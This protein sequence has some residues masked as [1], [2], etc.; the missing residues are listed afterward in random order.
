MISPHQ[1]FSSNILLKRNKTMEKKRKC[2]HWLESD[3]NSNNRIQKKDQDDDHT[4]VSMDEF[5]FKM[6][7]ALV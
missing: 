5:I 7:G 4:I 6:Q 2:I 3:K 1:L